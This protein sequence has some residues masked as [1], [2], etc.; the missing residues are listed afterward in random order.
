MIGA[1]N[2][3]GQWLVIPAHLEAAAHTGGPH[4]V[5]EHQA[6]PPFRRARGWCRTA[7][8]YL[9]IANAQVWRTEPAAVDGQSLLTAGQGPRSELGCKY[10]AGPE[11][12][13]GAK[14][15]VSGRWPA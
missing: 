5:V 11:R 12:L 2:V 8:K 3:H 6:G 7:K 4:G 10:G 9:R 15:S 14:T 1:D 13:Q